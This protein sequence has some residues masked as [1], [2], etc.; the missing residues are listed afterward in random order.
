MARATSGVGS[1]DAALHRGVAWILRAGLMV[2]IA[3]MTVGLVL[4]ERQGRAETSHVLPLDRIAPQLLHGDAAA[5]L[6]AGII[7]LF[8]SPLAAIVVAFAGFCWQRD[9]R[10]MAVTGTLILLALAGIAVA[11]R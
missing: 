10:F 4:A 1:G 7:L 9:V 8:L 11:V 6:D 3:V 5:V 2:S